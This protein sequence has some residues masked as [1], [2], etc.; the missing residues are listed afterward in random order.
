MANVGKPGEIKVSDRSNAA[1]APIIELP[2]SITVKDLADLLH[3]TSIEAIKQL[4]RNGIM[5]SINMI[6]NYDVAS[7][8]ASGYGYEVKPKAKAKVSASAAIRI[9][10][11][12]RE[13]QGAGMQSRPPVVTIMGHVDHGKTRL[14]DAIRQTDVM[15]SE[16]GGITQHIGAYQVE[17]NG[18]KVTFLDTPGHEAFTAMRARGAQVT[19]IAVLVVAA[20]DGVMPQTIEAMNHAK[21]AGVPIIVAIN[22][23]DKPEATP[24]V[25]KQ[26][27]AANGLVVEEWGGD[28]IAVGV[29]AK[30]KLGIPELLENILLLAEM[31]DLKANPDKAATGV[32]IEAEMDKTRGPLATVLVQ[33]GTL[34]P[35]DILVVGTTMGKIKAMYNDKGKQVRK[36]EPATP[37]SILGLAE[38]PG[39]GDAFNAVADETQ[40]RSIIQKRQIAQKQ[41][42]SKGLR[43][44]TVFKDITSGKVKELAIILK[45]DVQGSVEP[46]RNSLE[47]LS[48]AEVQLKIIHTSVGK[49]TEGDVMLA[50]AS[51]GLVIGFNT[52]VDTGARRLADAQSIDIRVYSIIYA[53]IDDVEKAVKGMLE[54]VIVEVIEGRAEVRQIFSG[55]KGLKAAG[56]MIIEG[57]ISRNLPVRVIRKGKVITEAPI[58]SL[59][60]FKDD[61]K[62]VEKGFECGIGLKDYNDLQVGDILESYTKQKST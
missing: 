45:T 24:D 62:E 10:K 48:S 46:I 6:V 33:N 8:V 30:E 15:A 5:A 12:V 41:P 61:V 2:A 55:G 1:N 17:V 36:A 20:D 34:K 52:E 43:L 35:G 7:L 4:M 56:C 14:L 54:P 22:K 19:D 25:V 28:V 40:A 57:K 9:K 3:I 60:R 59:R 47:K 31:E 42:E 53:L 32:V 26:Q 38:V 51:H 23:I 21:A 49:I 58:M 37:V 27:L 16:A 18:K 39:V 13:E 50:L 29:S 44:D 11:Q